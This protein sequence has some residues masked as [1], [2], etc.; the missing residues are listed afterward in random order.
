MSLGLLE[1]FTLHPSIAQDHTST[2]EKMNWFGLSSHQS[3]L[4]IYEGME[5]EVKSLGPSESSKFL[6][7]HN[8]PR[9]NRSF[10]CA[11]DASEIRMQRPQQNS[12]SASIVSSKPLLLVFGLWSLVQQSTMLAR[13]VNSGGLSANLINRHRTVLGMPSM[14]AANLPTHVEQA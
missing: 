5:R 3:M 1:G 12:D 4:T 10:R 8:P 13:P 9:G 6:L 2:L 7:R 11:C 14:K